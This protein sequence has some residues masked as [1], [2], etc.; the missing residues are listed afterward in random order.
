MAVI[1]IEA[2][3][4]TLGSGGGQVDNAVKASGGK[5][6]FGMGNPTETWLIPITLA[7]PCN[8]LEIVY[9]SDGGNKSTDILLNGNFLGT[10]AMQ[11]A[12][13]Y[14]QA[15]DPD[16]LRTTLNGITIPA[17][18]HVLKF[19]P[20]GTD[21]PRILDFIELTESSQPVSPAPVI[22]STTMTAGNPNFSATL[23]GGGTLNIF[24]NG[25]IQ[26]SQ[27][28]TANSSGVVSVLLSFSVVSG[29]VITCRANCTG[30]AQSVVS[31]QVTIQAASQFGNV[32]KSQPFTK[33]NCASGQNGSAV[34][35]TVAVNTHY[36]ST[37][38]AA[39]T[40][41]DN[42]IS[43]NG[44]AYANT[45]GT[46]TLLPSFVSSITAAQIANRATATGS[47]TTGSS[48]VPAGAVWSI[49]AGSATN[50]TA[51]IN[52]ATGQYS[53]IDTGGTAAHNCTFTI[54]C[55]SAQGNV[56]GTIPV[57]VPVLAAVVV[58]YAPQ[59]TFSGYN[60]AQGAELVISN[61]VRSADGLGFMWLPLAAFG[62]WAI[63]KK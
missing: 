60:A 32:A 2:E 46:C 20:V 42:N 47:A 53:I 27:T 33:N 28:A 10:V 43:A 49:V 1:K 39:D 9:W 48:N 5:V 63:S 6:A 59:A 23:C 34:V 16:P 8:K 58:N 21:G 19:V 38:A 7:N 54:Q 25:A 13:P 22:T 44:Q 17:G 55:K 26:A 45:N 29:D 52:P 37:Q 51:T 40:L 41:A 35:Y 30:M 62:L 4:G 56:L 31:N 14:S 57:T 24:K 12:W 36:A 61:D 15:S 3:T 11:N 50:C 18:S